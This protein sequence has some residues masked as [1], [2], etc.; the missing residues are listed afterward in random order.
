[1]TLDVLLAYDY[2]GTQNTIGS[3]VFAKSINGSLAFVYRYI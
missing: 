2:E 1:M 3:Y